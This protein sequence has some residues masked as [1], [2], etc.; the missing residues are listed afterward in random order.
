MS[1]WIQLTAIRESRDHSLFVSFP[2]LFADFH[3]LHRLLMPS[4]PPCAL[5]RLAVEISNSRHHQ[6]SQLSDA[7]ALD[8]D[9]SIANDIYS[10]TEPDRPKPEP[11]VP[12][13][14]TSKNP[15][16][17]LRCDHSGTRYHTP[18]ETET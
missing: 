4:H 9:G 6:A 3:A 1:L 14:S 8:P 10:L 11:P 7:P 16:V 5:N 18:V 12:T 17:N 2:R 15:K 13:I